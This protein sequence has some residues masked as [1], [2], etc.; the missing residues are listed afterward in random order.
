M[1]DFCV[2]GIDPRR[3]RDLMTAVCAPV[4]VVTTTHE[5]AAYGA[6]VSS[7][8]SLSLEPP[9][10]TIALDRRSALLAHILAV[11]RFGVNLLGHNQE[12]L[13][14]LFARH[15]ADRFAET[16]WHLDHGLPR[17]DGAAGWV[18]CGVHS[19]VPGGD[20]ELILGH[21]EA[22]GRAELPPLIYAHRTFGTHSR[23]DQRPRTVIVDQIAACAS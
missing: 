13:A 11:G 16:G 19:V 20:H 3:F 17:L 21:V 15:G 8:A 10:V 9:L 23:Y 14:T 1:N 22:A 6:T 18:V 7:F 5:V 12:D 2:T 4:T